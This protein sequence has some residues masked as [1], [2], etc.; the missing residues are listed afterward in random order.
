MMIND[1]MLHKDLL[2]DKEEEVMSIVVAI[3]ISHKLHTDLE[4]T[5][6]LICVWRF[7]LNYYYLLSRT[8]HR[9]VLCLLRRLPLWSG[10]EELQY[11][12]E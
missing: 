7:P 3:Q 1:N 11:R 9:P 12:A 8:W 4:S 10:S 2:A 6:F 5:H